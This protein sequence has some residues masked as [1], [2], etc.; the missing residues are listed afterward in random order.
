MKILESSPSIVLC[1]TK[2]LCIVWVILDDSGALTGIHQCLIPYPDQF[3]I[4]L[5]LLLLNPKISLIIDHPKQ[6]I[7]DCMDHKPLLIELEM[8]ETPFSHIVPP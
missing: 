6:S 4:K 2:F 1:F 8:N 7:S 3:I 5:P